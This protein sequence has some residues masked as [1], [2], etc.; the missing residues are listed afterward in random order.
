MAEK[1]TTY[2]LL[3]L[4]ESPLVV[5]EAHYANGTIQKNYCTREYWEL[6]EFKTSLIGKVASESDLQKLI[7]LAIANEQKER[8]YDEVE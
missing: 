6:L 5:Y 3:T 4:K 8:T 2:K 1:S 7:E